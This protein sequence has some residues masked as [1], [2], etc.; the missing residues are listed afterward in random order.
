MMSGKGA[1][2]TFRR[3]TSMTGISFD[4]ATSEATPPPPPPYPQNPMAG[5]EFMEVEG[6][7]GRVSEYDHLSTA[8]ILSPRYYNR[9]SSTFDS[10]TETAPFLRTCGLCNRRL[11][12]G[13]D[14]YMYRGDKAFCS[15]ECREQQMKQDER[16]ER[17]SMAVPSDG[18]SHNHRTEVG[19]AA[20]ETTEK[21]KTVAAA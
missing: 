15:Q 3:T 19:A 10:N 16:K 12:P 21:I 11:A 18:E 7:Q 13:R 8:M 20:A 2:P 1:R 5:S 6:L 14:I 17:R 4:V 9:I